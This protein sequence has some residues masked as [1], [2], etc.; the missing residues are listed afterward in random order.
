MKR[1]M[2]TK[3]KKKKNIKTIVGCYSSATES[4]KITKNHNLKERVSPRVQV[5][6]V[7]PLKQSWIHLFLFISMQ[8][9]WFQHHASSDYCHSLLNAASVLT[10]PSKAQLQSP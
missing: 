7:L 5:L 9:P 2:I 10:T 4:E 3:T 8:P 6:P 1:Q